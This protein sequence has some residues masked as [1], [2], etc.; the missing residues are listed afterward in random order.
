LEHQRFTAGYDCRLLR[1]ES[2]E[3]DPADGQW[4]TDFID[5]DAATREALLTQGGRRDKSPRKRLRRGGLSRR[6]ADSAEG[7]E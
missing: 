3:L 1:C 6:T 2:G 7:A 5:G 4:W